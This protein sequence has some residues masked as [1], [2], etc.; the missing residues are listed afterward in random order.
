MAEAANTKPA[1]KPKN[2]KPKKKRSLGRWFKE[3]FSEL[4]KV[5][6]PTFAKTLTQLG[7]VIVVVLFFLL[8]LM[9]MDA[10]LSWLYKL[11]VKGLDTT[12]AVSAA[13]TSVSG[14]LSASSG[15]GLLL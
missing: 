10:L 4:K 1:N 7:V 9:G 15:I 13:L 3:V 6:W 11:L 12:E 8:V 14:Y 5:S 2:D